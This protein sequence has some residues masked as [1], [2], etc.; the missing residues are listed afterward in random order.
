[1]VGSCYFLFHISIFQQFKWRS[2]PF[3]ISTGL[4]NLPLF[5]QLNSWHLPFLL[6]FCFHLSNW[7][8]PALRPCEFFVLPNHSLVISP[9][10]CVILFQQLKWRHTNFHSFDEPSLL[11]SSFLGFR[12]LTNQRAVL[13]IRLCPI[14]S[15]ICRTTV[16]VNPSSFLCVIFL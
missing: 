8:P 15:L 16:F 14:F 11:S 4:T 7:R 2:R 9:R 6:H 10:F 5:Q 3:N 1:M 13:A 12:P